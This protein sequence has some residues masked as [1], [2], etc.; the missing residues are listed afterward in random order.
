M[1]SFSSKCWLT[2]ILSLIIFSCSDQ[3][4][5]V[6]FSEFEA[7]D[8][9]EIALPDEFLA[10]TSWT[11]YNTLD[12]QILVEYGLGSDNNLVIHQVDFLAGKYLKPIIIPQ[13]GPNGYNSS[14]ASVIFK[15][16]DSL[17]V[18]PSLAAHFHLYNSSGQLL[19]KI[20]Y[21][22]PDDSK[23]IESG[24]Y[25]S[26]VFLDQKMFTPVYQSMR[27]DDPQIFTKTIPI[28]S[29]D[30]NANQFIDSILYPKYT[31]NKMTTVDQLSPSLAL[32]DKDSIAINYHFSDSLYFWNPMSNTTSSLYMSNDKFGKG[33]LFDRY[34][35]KGLVFKIKEVDFEL[36]KY[37]NERLYRIISYVPKEKRSLG[38]FRNPTKSIEKN[39]AP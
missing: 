26:A 15:S 11:T 35:D 28:R 32:I 36:I 39:G 37:H 21:N 30:F 3:K 1:L 31:K 12:R 17:L 19:N 18:F 4:S 34:P 13:Q 27:F 8:S 10:Y 9:L 25:S 33:I 16:K 29:F 24:Y 38:G 6:D 14:G 2:P 23:Y 7:L 22:A 20:P 5:A